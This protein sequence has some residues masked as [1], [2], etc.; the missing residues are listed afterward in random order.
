MKWS[1]K[2][3]LFP[4]AVIIV[5]IAVSYYFYNI[6]PDT[7]PTHFNS[8]GIPNDYSSKTTLVLLGTGLT[9]GIYLLLTFVP[10]IDPLRKKFESK[11]SVFLL[12]RD[13][14][15]VFIPCIFILGYISAREGTYRSDLMGVLVGVLLVALGN[16]LPRL[17]R[18]FFFGIRSPWTLASETVWVKT[19]RISGFLFVIAGIAMILLTI[20]KVKLSISMLTV[21]APLVLFSGFIYPYFLFRKIQ[22]EGEKENQ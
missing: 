8:D 3:D 4:L 16:Y 9:V 2:R 10:M 13:L 1:F 12:F 20:L 7:V 22:K 21:F 17:P 14:S 19:H 5:F 11:Y 18:N 6:L 15:M